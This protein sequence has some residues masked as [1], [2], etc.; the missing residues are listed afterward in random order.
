MMRKMIDLSRASIFGTSCLVQGL[1]KM[2]MNLSRTRFDTN[3]AH[4]LQRSPNKLVHEDRFENYTGGF[5]PKLY[6]KRNLHTHTCIL[7]LKPS[8]AIV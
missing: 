6:I 3:T 2:F 1:I 4:C 8:R 7:Q 5:R